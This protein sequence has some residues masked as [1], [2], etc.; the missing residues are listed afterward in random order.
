VRRPL[1]ALAAVPFIAALLLLVSAA[2][3]DDSSAEAEKPAPVV[4][5]RTR[6]G[7]AFEH[8]RILTQQRLF[9]LAH[10]ISLLAAS[11]LDVPERMEEVQDA[12]AVWRE[13][14]AETIDDA[15]A[16]LSTYYFGDQPAD[17][18]HLTQALHL[19]EVLP[20][21]PNS[22]ALKA[23][24]ATFPQALR[25]P[26]YDLVAQFRLHEYLSQITVG[27]ETDARAVHCKTRLPGDSLTLLEARYGFWREINEP[28]VNRAR[29]VLEKEWSAMDIG[30][31]ES[32]EEWLK[33]MRQEAHV[34]GS[35]EDCL[36]FSEW[37]KTP[38]AALS[39]AFHAAPAP[40][41]IPASP[42]ANVTPSLFTPAP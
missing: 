6:L 20:Y 7:Y 36:R 12:Y 31:A 21:E 29:E 10:G 38:D 14:Q 16:E 28:L 37:L 33:A 26:R 11:C 18:Q 34:S 5:D 39:Q 25:R 17:W 4:L 24:C 27:L 1:A 40:E 19:K 2:H 8:P 32:L 30:P 35:V 9:G 42:H 13:R 15:V 41:P 3:A 22:E 23:A